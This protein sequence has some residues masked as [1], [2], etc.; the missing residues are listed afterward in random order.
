MEKNRFKLNRY[1]GLDDIEYKGIRY[2]INLFDLSIDESYYKPTRINY[3]ING[4]YI[5]Y[6]IWGD[7][8]KT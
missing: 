6:E 5:E 7:K 1:Y 3:A 4:K 2:V 8:D